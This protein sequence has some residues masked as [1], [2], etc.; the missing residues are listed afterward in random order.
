[1]ALA[2]AWRTGKRGSMAPIEQAKLWAL[3]TILRKQ[4]EDD[5]KYAWMVTQVRVVGGGHPCRE[6]VRQFFQRVDQDD[7]WHPGKRG[8]VGRPR[9]LTAQLVIGIIRE[10]PP[11]TP[12]DVRA[13][14]TKRLEQIILEA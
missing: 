13:G 1:M 14:Q 7:D 10:M 3:R 4:G 2:R 8:D 5:D 12:S 11:G 6:A 9:T